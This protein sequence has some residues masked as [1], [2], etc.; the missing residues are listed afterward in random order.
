M[1]IIENIKK[2]LVLIV[3]IYVLE[4]YIGMDCL[5]ATTL[6]RTE[7]NNET[8]QHH[9][10]QPIVEHNIFSPGRKEFASPSLESGNSTKPKVRPQIIL[11]GI[12]IAGDY[13]SASLVQIGRNLKRGE[14]E[15]MTVKIGESIG[16]YKVSKIFPE[17]IIL[18]TEDDS[19]EVFLYD[20]KI[21]KRRI[22]VRT[23]SKPTTVTSTVSLS[24]TM[25][26]TKREAEIQKESI[27]PSP[28]S[29][30]SLPLRRPLRRE[31]IQETKEPSG[32]PETQDTSLPITA[33]APSPST[34]SFT[35]STTP[36][37]VP[38]T[39]TPLTPPISPIPIPVPPGMGKSLPPP[40]Q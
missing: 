21:P 26:E 18:E 1:K 10:L 33:P 12:T 37:P 15:L 38:L 11:Y 20:P 27:S 23:E 28:S 24:P 9:S 31:G 19:F 29:I 32:K 5:G 36:L 17:K 13:Q 2:Y 25:A 8:P 7:G 40:S 35:P 34:P 14:R 30:P 22:E 39:P 4:I 3:Y 6:Q 16:N